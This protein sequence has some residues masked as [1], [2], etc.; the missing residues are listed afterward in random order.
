MKVKIT[1][2]TDTQTVLSMERY[3]LL[4]MKAT[5]LDS[6]HDDVMRSYKVY[7]EKEKNCESF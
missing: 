7:E 6:I 5:L 2:D 3:K 1:I 4:V